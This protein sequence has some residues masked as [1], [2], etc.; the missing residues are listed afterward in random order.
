MSYVQISDDMKTIVFVIP[1]LGIGGAEKVCTELGEMLAKSNL[2]YIVTF[3]SKQEVPLDSSVRHISLAMGDGVGFKV[4]GTLILLKRLRRTLQELYPYG[5]VSFMERANIFCRIALAGSRLEFIPT[6]H[7]TV[8]SFSNRGRVARAFID[9]FYRFVFRKNTKFIT[10]SPQIRNDLKYV[11]GLTNVD[12]VANGLATDKYK[13]V[14]RKPGSILRLLVVSR[15]HPEKQTSIAILATELLRK[16]GIPVTLTIIGDGPERAF[17]ENLTCDLNLNSLVTF[18]GAVKTPFHGN[19]EAD[20]LLVTS[21]SESF[22]IGMI[23][24]ILCGIPVLA[25]D[26]PTGPK[27]ISTLL[28]GQGIRLVPVDSEDHSVLATTLS[29]ALAADF[30]RSGSIANETCAAI[31]IIRDVF[32]IEKAAVGYLSAIDELHS[33]FL[34]KR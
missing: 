8:Q 20:C 10:V 19:L 32:S 13:Y 26:C 23:E 14:S 4:F 25:L 6:V 28:H 3:G 30:Y 18:V 27:E 17:L 5:V 33:S 1:S 16:R 34:P 22:G 12:V 24:A 21:R 15:L 7:A 29:T 2:V 31:K 9:I 11:Y